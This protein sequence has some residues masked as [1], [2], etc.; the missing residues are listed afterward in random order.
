MSANPACVEI[1]NS[2]TLRGTRSKV[3][4]DIG[5]YL[6]GEAVGWGMIA[7]T[8]RQLRS[9][10]FRQG[11]WRSLVSDRARWPPSALAGAPSSLIGAMQ[12]DKKT[13]AGR[14]AFVLPERIGKVR[15]G[16][17]SASASART[18]PRDVRLF[19]FTEN[20]RCTAE[21]P[22]RHASEGVL[23]EAEA[24]AHVRKCWAA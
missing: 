18:S 6:H 11:F 9:V 12:A 24:A 20:D 16:G 19:G 14:F 2:G 3:L 21:R 7:A 15:C 10:C 22:S 1:L 13:R 4:R 8:R 17:R 5:K 23:N